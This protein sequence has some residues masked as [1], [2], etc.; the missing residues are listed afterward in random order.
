MRVSNYA[1]LLIALT[2]SFSCWAQSFPSKPV[3]VIVGITPGSPPDLLARAAGSQMEK[4]LGQPFLVENRPGANSTI[5]AKAVAGA[6]P[7]GYTLFFG[8]ATNISPVF[9]KENSVDAAKEL[10]PISNLFTAPYGFFVSA[11]QPFASWQE[12][13]AYAKANPGK[14]NFG[15]TA[16]I[17]DLLMNVL[18]N[19]SGIDYTVVTYKGGP[20]LLRALVSGEVDFTIIVPSVLVGPTQAGSVRALFSTR[21]FAQLPNMPTAAAIGIPN[22]DVV[23]NQGLWAPHGTP[24]DIAQNLSAAAAAAAKAPDVSEQARKAFGGET[25]GTTPEEQMR[26]YESD[27][28]FWQ[29]AARLS[30]FKPQ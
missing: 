22:F 20:E 29:E 11:K 14:A 23:A 24:R 12:V 19:R 2:A 6:P 28:K 17:T 4:R 10:A 21:A 15:S 5:A 7:D 25:L 1:A 26:T 27:L 8:S 18:K 16:F 3:R 9:V 30:N 13:V